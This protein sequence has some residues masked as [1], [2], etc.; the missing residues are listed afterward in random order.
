MSL[1]VWLPL[2]GD[3]HN[4]GLSNIN[5]TN[6]VTFATSGKIGASCLNSQLGW[7]AIPEMAGKKQMSFAYWVKLNAGTT[8]NW[9][10]LFSWYSTNGTSDHRSR[11]EFYY[12]NSGGNTEAMTTGVWYY[13]NSNSGLTQR[14]IG[15]WYHYAF[16]IDYTTGITQFFVDGV[17]WKTTTNADTSHYIKGNNFLL[18]ESSLDCSINDFR[19]YDHI[20]STK[21]VEE[22]AK[23]L[24]LHYKLDT[25]GLN[26]LPSQY[27]KVSFLQSSGTQYIN[28]G[29]D[30]DSLDVDFQYTTV[31]SGS[32][33]RSILGARTASNT[34]IITVAH[35]NGNLLPSPPDASVG[36]QDT[37]RHTIQTGVYFGNKVYYDGNLALSYSQ[38][39]T[40][41]F[42]IYLFG[43]NRGDTVTGYSSCKIYQ[44][45]L[46]K[47]G[48]IVRYMVP[49]VRVSDNVAGMY[50]IVEG[51]FYTN[52]G[53]GTF[54]VG[55][56]ENTIYDCS[57]YQ[58]NGTIT[59]S[60]AAVSESSR[61]SIAT[62]F[63]N[64]Q[65]IRVDN[66]P[67]AFLPKDA[68][69][70]NLWQYATS[71]SNPISCTE[72][73]GWNFENS[74]GIRF[75]VYISGVGYKVAQS[76][77]TP[78]STLNNWHMLTGTMDQDNIKIYYDG[79][80]VG[81]VAK[82]SANGIGY[83]NNYL[84]IGAEAA[85]NTTTPAASAYA[86]NLSDVRIYATALTP[87]QIKELYNTSMSIDDKGNIHARE[88]V[89]L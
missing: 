72:G 24:V 12:Y 17:L 43:E 58:N 69:T 44:V 59:G 27:Q 46:Y 20:L 31:Y 5:L 38:Q 64:G 16:T 76:S 85:G 47:N 39:T 50:D 74:S 60:L 26:T 68:I 15:Q 33:L 35:Y 18:R 4:Q 78:A 2:N 55:E 66:R 63:A 82:G 89:E 57:G 75:P 65:Y 79:E 14:K 81:T 49:C 8:T 42:N 70:V 41:N 25:I 83:A 7:F 40:C 54:T 34:Q 6:T 53:T 28:S 48:T 80:E 9:L 73:G 52:A 21:E 71:W 11:Q 86:G 22:I 19:L 87:E 61:Y 30:A 32:N 67:A 36:A 10:D 23:G 88:L 45:R 1:Q 51:N 77:I 84:F 13:N 56:K 3:L 29:T 62:Q 37:N